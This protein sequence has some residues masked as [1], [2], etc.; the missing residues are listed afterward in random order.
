MKFFQNYCPF[1]LITCLM[2]IGS[3]LRLYHLDFNSFWLDEAATHVFTQ[4]SIGEYWQLLSSLGEV[5]PPLF[6]LVE[7]LVLP[8]GSSE[9][10]YRLFPA[11]F[12]IATIP[13]FYLAGKKMAGSTVGILMAVLITFSPFHIQY[14][15]DARMYTMLLF[16]T[17]IALILYLEAIKS[18][19]R[20]YWVLFGVVS[21]LA[22]WTHFMAF[23]FIGVLI[24][25]SIFYQV[26]EKTSPKNLLLSIGVIAVL[27]TPLIVI[28][29][30]LFF[31]RIGSPPTWG[32]TGD[33]FI[34]KSVIILLGNNPVSLLF[35][36]MIFCLGL[37]WLFFELRKQFFFIIFV[38]AL[39]LVT[40][41][42]LSYKMPIDPRYFIFLLPLLYAVVAS[43]SLPFLQKVRA[44]PVIAIF[45]VLFICIL[46]PQLYGYY[47]TPINEDWRAA[48]Y[49]IKNTAKANDIII[50]MPDYNQ[51]PF[52]FYYKNSTYGTIQINTASKNDL[53]KI[54]YLRCKNN[55]SAY[56]LVTGDLLSADR[57]GEATAWIGSSR[58][59]EIANFNGVHV[60]KISLN[61]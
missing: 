25:Y 2:V 30:G 8:F 28:I 13:L 18:N 12:G 1:F 31:N 34:V 23:I 43:A 52:N 61:C 46:T 55:L 58:I 48:S 14:S 7:K 3:F 41:V 54:N 59:T 27:L 33:L 47:N 5:H 21:A 11:L 22:I 17:T 10:L 32:Y 15:Q 35:F 40:G 45:I 56:I 19:D 26:K 42:I 24:I 44:K 50:L 38:L 4:Q 16:I 60:G 36:A 29:N 53:E 20:K 37:V 39:S 6:Y 9:F 49:F 57:S 51:I